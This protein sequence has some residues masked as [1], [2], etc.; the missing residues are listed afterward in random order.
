MHSGPQPQRKDKFYEPSVWVISK[1][2]GRASRHKV[3]EAP[4]TQAVEKKL[5]MGAAGRSSQ[6]STERWKGGKSDPGSKR[7]QS[8]GEDN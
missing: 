6:K 1:A 3:T 4:E 2:R 7:P 5:Y 8:E